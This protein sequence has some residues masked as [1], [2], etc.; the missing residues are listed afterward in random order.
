MPKV[1]SAFLDRQNAVREWIGRGIFSQKIRTQKELARRIGM[2]PTTF[3]SRISHPENFR[4]EEI[5]AIERIIGR[6]EE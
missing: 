5:W 3:S 1:S 4:L 2:P 6:F